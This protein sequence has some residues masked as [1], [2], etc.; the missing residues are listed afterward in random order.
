MT[1]LGKWVPTT[2]APRP[3]I[4]IAPNETVRISRDSVPTEYRLICNQRLKV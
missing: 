4:L 2:I 1:G 3:S